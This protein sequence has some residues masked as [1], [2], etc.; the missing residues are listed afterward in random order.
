[1][2]D[3]VKRERESGRETIRYTQRQTERARHTERQPNQHQSI[4]EKEVN[5]PSTNNHQ[6]PD[7]FTA[8]GV[9]LFA[10]PPPP[11]KD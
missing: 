2:G 1:M 8:I 5:L 10:P 9:E 3:R 7:T 4:E 6:M 11:H